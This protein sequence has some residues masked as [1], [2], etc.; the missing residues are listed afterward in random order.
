MKKLV[1]LFLAVAAFACLASGR[2]EAASYAR[3]PK[4]VK[5]IGY[6]SAISSVT[7]NTFNSVLASSN[8]V[9]G[10]VYAVTLTSGT[11]GD[12]CVLYDTVTAQG[13]TNAASTSVGLFTSQLGP[14]LFF[15]STS[16]NT[17]VVFDPPIIFFYGLYGTCT[18]TGTGAM[19]EFEEGRGLSGN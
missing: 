2:S 17:T 4:A 1:S 6:S 12:Y 18:N 9:P 19:V 10:A 13:L 7:V 16:A 3:S 8:T 11:A 5:N 14:R 15:G